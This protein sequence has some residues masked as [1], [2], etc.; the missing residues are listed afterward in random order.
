MT[1][2]CFQIDLRNRSF[3]RRFQSPLSLVSFHSFRAAENLNSPP[4]F[5]RVTVLPKRNFRHCNRLDRFIKCCPRTWTVMKPEARKQTLKKIS[6]WFRS[7]TSVFSKWI[8]DSGF[9]RTAELNRLKIYSGWHTSR[10]FTSPMDH[11]R[12]VN[13]INIGVY[14]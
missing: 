7:L 8:I 12:L 3:T 13:N 9:V 4:R 2:V 5:T 11:N 10:K 1:D 14:T 6:N